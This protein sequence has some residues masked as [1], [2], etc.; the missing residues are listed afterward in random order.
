MERVSL[1]EM[2]QSGQKVK[3]ECGKQAHRDFGAEVRGG[4]LD[5][6]HH[7]YTMY[8]STGT[9]LYAAS[10]LPHQMEE[11]KK[12]HPGRRFEKINGCYLPDIKHRQDKKQY[13]KEYGNFVELD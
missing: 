2:S 5:S 6:Q 3:C 9:R 8:G 4:V 12:K 11:A 1:E 7:E 13:L 10:Y